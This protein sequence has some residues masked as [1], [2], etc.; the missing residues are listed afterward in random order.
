M[1]NPSQTTSTHPD[2]PRWT[3]VLP[4]NPIG[5]TSSRLI[6]AATGLVKLIPDRHV[7]TVAVSE[8]A[9]VRLFGARTPGTTT[10]A[11][12]WMHGGGYVIGTARQD[13]TIC[14]TYAERLGALV[15]SVEYRLAPDNPYPA[16]LEDCYA[17]LTWLAG[18]P[19]VDPTRIVIAGA[20][21]GGGLAAALTNLAHDR[22]EVAPAFQL[23]VY[24]MLDDRT[25]DCPPEHA[26]SHHLW[27]A[28]SNV[29][30]WSAYLG[31]ADRAAAVPARRPDLIG[32][33]PTWIGVGTHDLFHDEDL[34][35]ARR[36]ADAGVPV[37]TEV[38]PGAFHAFDVVGARTAVARAFVDSQIAAV[39]R[40]LG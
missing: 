24:P 29:F 21:A 14:R 17:A 20:S 7:E 35:Y 37:E 28:R 11:L 25:V 5:P 38:V 9:S 30:G 15:A 40:V 23:L 6:R 27:S 16:G 39:R 19:T 22:G 26:S 34:A 33:P 3:R 31:D 1:S 4:A 8:T 13:D 12:V 18:Q 2:L 32:L 10:P 36:L